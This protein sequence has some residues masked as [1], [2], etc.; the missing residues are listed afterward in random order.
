MKKLNKPILVLAAAVSFLLGACDNDKIND[1]IVVKDNVSFALDIQPILT[2]ECASCHNP[3][4]V[5]PDLRE[6]YAYESIADLI[7]EGD[8]IPG[9]AEGS[10]LIE[11]LEGK[12]DDGNTMPPSGPMTPLKI[13]LIKKWIDEGALDN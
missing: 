5:A 1:E 12:S 6:G 8:V 4:E 13:A 3:T 9:N 2:G 7:L 10:E 11:M